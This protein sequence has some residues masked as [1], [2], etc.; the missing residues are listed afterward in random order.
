M[1]NRLFA[2]IGATLAGG[3]CAG[4]AHAGTTTYT[5]AAAYDVAT[6]GLTY[7][8]FTD[9]PTPNPGDSGQGTFGGG[10]PLAGYSSLAG[11][12]FT[13]PNLNGFVNVNSADFY[14]SNDL[15]VP[16]AV[17]SQYDGAAPDILNITLPTA[18]TAFSLDFNTLFNSTTATFSLG[19]GFS[20]IFADTATTSN[21]PGGT[22]LDF[23]GFT[24][25][26][27]FTTITFSVPSQQS[28]VVADFNYGAALATGAV[29]EPSAWAMMIVGFATIGYFARRRSGLAPRLSKSQPNPAPQAL[30][31]LRRDATQRRRATKT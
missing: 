31:I 8:N 7:G 4:T 3:L 18:E 19:N 24:S 1:K 17:N 15:S 29:P 2:T 12:V 10:N 26:T 28:F 25:T 21:S 11:V 6:T 5:S 27:P 23:L 16:Y 20:T 13:T 30:S 22:S 9:V 14:S